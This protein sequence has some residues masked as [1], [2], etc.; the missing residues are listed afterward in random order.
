MEQNFIK[1]EARF[2]FSKDWINIANQTQKATIDLVINYQNKTF[3]I[4]PENQPTGKFTFLQG[5]ANS[6][7]LWIT[8]LETI[9]E[10]TFFAQ[11]ELEL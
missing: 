10:A 11:K 9:K 5:G 3:N 7:I 6:I 2:K 8:I 4:T 1:T